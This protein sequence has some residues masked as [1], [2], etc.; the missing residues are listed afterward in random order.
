[1]L[2][3]DY[4]HR[5]S[6]MSDLCLWDPS[7]ETVMFVEVKSNNDRL[8]ET[9]KNWIDVMGRAKIPVQICHVLTEEENEDRE[10]R[11]KARVLKAKSKKRAHDTSDGEDSD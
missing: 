7:D 2:V 9:Q 1:M 4:G 3:E 8:S 10:T 6:G 11:T 5:S